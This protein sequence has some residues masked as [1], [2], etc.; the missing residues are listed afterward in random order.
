MLKDPSLET[1]RPKR[2]ERLN[3]F[4]RCKNLKES[5]ASRGQNDPK[6]VP[7]SQHSA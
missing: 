4:E 2:L 7:D 1:Q 3:R 5:K 6:N